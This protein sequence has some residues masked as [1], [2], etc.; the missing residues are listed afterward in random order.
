ML[1]ALAESKLR[2]EGRSVITEAAS[3]AYVVTPVLAALA[4]ARVQAFTRG[5]RFGTF[6]EVVG[7]TRDLAARAGVLDR[8]EIVADRGR[9]RFEEADVLTNS[10]HLRPLDAALVARLRP[11]TA[12]PL[13]FE[14]WEF[15]ASDLDLD[16]C[17]RR[18]VLVAGT[19][20]R[21]PAVDVFSFL[22]P[23][24]LKLL[25][26]A[27]VAV[28]RSRVVLLCD[29]P[30]S[31]YI[32]RSLERLASKLTVAEAPTAA[33]FGPDAVVVAMKPSSAPAEVAKLSEKIADA[34]P[35]AVIVQYWGD[36]DRHLFQARGMSVWPPEPPSPGHMAVLP[37]DIGPEAI[38]RLQTGGLKVA[39]VLL[40]P[41]EDRSAEDLA[42]IQS[43]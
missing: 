33:P 31:P 34:Y 35:D 19:N 29:N 3:G 14:A 38:V 42:F 17:R 18:G 12:L 36:L 2:L 37:G 9:L 4:G 23:M 32:A 8:I 24:A 1:D 40:K 10:G 43:L 21:H 41:A 5:S 20:E 15:R 22:G 13:M 27:G 7:A 11:G 16:A 30:F 28:Y 6:E 39:E 26:D 25:F